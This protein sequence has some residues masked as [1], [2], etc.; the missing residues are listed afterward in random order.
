MLVDG[1]LCNALLD[2]GSQ[3][4]SLTSDFVAS[5]LPDV[6]I[7]PLD[8]LVTIRG[9]GG[10]IL[11]Y[12]G[13]IEVDIKLDP[14]DVNTA[15]TVLVLVIGGEPY[16]ADVPLVIGTN[17]MDYCMPTMERLQDKSA[18]WKLAHTSMSRHADGVLGMIRTT[19]SEVVPPQS[20]KVLTGLMRTS[21]R[22]PS[23]ALL[24]MMEAVPDQNLPGGLLVTPTLMEFHDV[25][26]STYRL[27][28]E[29]Q[30]LLTQPVT[31]PPRATL[32]NLNQVTVEQPK[33]ETACSDSP[34]LSMF[35]WPD[36]QEHAQTLK[37]FVMHWSD[38]FSVNDL[39]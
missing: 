24:A 16:R 14:D 7:Q 9:A 35:K 39:D 10:N 30:N 11:P 4:T 19:K 34:L 31:V 3:V 38:V 13:F 23:A 21:S 27:K 17:L 20:R 8:E 26:V 12:D 5:A 6:V 33:E 1:A 18:A 22:L 2:T 36:N 25:H 28:V 37:D 15:N 32:C 29:V